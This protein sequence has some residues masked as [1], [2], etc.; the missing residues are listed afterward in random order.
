MVSFAT[1]AELSKFTEGLISPTDERSQPLL[2]GATA[3]IRH[4]AGWN[5]APAEEVA[6]AL[7]GGGD[8]LYLPSLKVN[9]ITSVTVNGEAVSPPDFEWSRRTGN[10]RLRSGRFPDSW[11][12][13]IV[14]FNSGYSTVPADLKAITLQMV[15]IAMS[16][17]TGATREQ[18]GQVAT[19]WAT[20]GPGVSGGLTI[21]DRDAQIVSKYLVPR[22]A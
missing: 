2:D 19:D 9:S 20:T 6:V 14:T 15:A 12:G 13:V 10:L 11:G 16:S 21:L 17:P 3:A 4:L 8:V 1:P 5:I 7:D 22:E 18:A